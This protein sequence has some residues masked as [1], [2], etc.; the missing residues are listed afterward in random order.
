ME[1]LLGKR[2]TIND[3]NI[4]NNKNNENDVF[5]NVAYSDMDMLKA[6]KNVLPNSKF[7]N[8]ELLE[9][10]AVPDD[11]VLKKIFD[12]LNEQEKQIVLNKY[13]YLLINTNK[14]SR[15]SQAAQ[16]IPFGGKSS[17]RRVRRR[18]TNK[19]KTRKAKKKTYKKK[20]K[21]NKKRKTRARTR[22]RKH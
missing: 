16:E 13:N 14:R 11:G 1:P 9:P 12:G 22:R 19:K 10:F 17:R 3:E 8:K 5:S 20:R 2:K 6:M 15:P 4:E 21:G 7:T 18:K